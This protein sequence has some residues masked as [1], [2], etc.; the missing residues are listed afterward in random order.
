MF[1]VHII[2]AFGF[3]CRIPTAIYVRYQQ[4]VEIHGIYS[5]RQK[6]NIFYIRAHPPAGVWEDTSFRETRRG[7]DVMRPSHW[8]C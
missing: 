4:H 2:V 7:S 1:A 8:L 6:E 3:A 5:Y